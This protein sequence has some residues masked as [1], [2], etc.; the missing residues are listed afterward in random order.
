MLAADG[1]REVSLT[2]W[3]LAALLLR[4]CSCVEF[5]DFLLATL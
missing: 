3:T 5:A 2:A 4:T 1:V